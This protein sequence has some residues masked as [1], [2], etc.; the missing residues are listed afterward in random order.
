MDIETQEVVEVN[1]RFT[2]LFGFSLPEDAPLQVRQIVVESGK[3]LDILYEKL[4]KER[5]FLP[6]EIRLFRHKHGFEVPV[7]RAGS[8]INISGKPYLLASMRDMTA[9]RRRQ[10]ELAQDIEFA[11]RVQQ[12]L[13]PMPAPSPFVTIRTLYHPTRFVS[14]DSY[15]LE[16]LREGTVLRG[17]LIDVSGHGLAS[18]LQTASVNV[19][20]REA[21]KLNLSLIENLQWV[22]ARAAKYFA[23]GAF[24]AMLGFELDFPGRE[25]RYVGAGITQFQFNGEKITVPGMF[26]GLWDD[27]EFHAGSAPIGTGDTFHFLTDGFTDVLSQPEHVDFWSSAGRGFDSDVAALERVAW[28]RI[29]RDDATGVCLKIMQELA[30][31]D[32]RGFRSF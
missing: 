20:L 8:V 22:N 13:L 25:M 6:A 28:S 14:G 3:N 9:E 27:A 23:D 11:S 7:E 29:L 19:L 2:E 5:S 31:G 26:V 21:E 12:A 16:W 18:A 1:R 32:C 30:E 17:F 24:A 10:T 4:L 15:Y